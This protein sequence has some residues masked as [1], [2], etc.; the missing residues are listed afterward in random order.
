MA[1]GTFLYDIF[2]SG[3][4]LALQ[5]QKNGADVCTSVPF[6][7]LLHEHSRAIV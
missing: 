2:F 1:K 4:G 3:E 6:Y 7:R 5:R